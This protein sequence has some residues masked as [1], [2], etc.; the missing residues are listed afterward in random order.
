MSRQ[1]ILHLAPGELSSVASIYRRAHATGDWP[2]QLVLGQVKSLAKKERPGG[3]GDFRPI[4]IFS[5][6]YRIWSSIASQ[7]WLKHVSAIMDHRL[8]GN[9]SSH[10]ASHLWRAV[11]DEVELSHTSGNAIAGVVFDL[12]K[13][14]N[15]LP[16]VVCLGLGK[17]VGIDHGSL[18]AWAGALGQM[19][20]RF[21]VL[22]SVSPPVR[23]SCGFA[24]GCGMSCLAMMLLDQIW[25]EWVKHHS[26]LCIPM[27]YVDNWEILTTDVSQIDTAI[28]ATYAL[29]NRLDL[30]V[31]RQKSFTWA[32]SGGFRQVLRQRGYTVRLDTADLGAHVTYS[33]QLRNSSLIARCES[34]LDFWLKLRL[35]F[36]SH[37]QKAQV[38]LRAAW[39]RALHAASATHLGLKNV[40]SL[41]SAYMTALKLDRPGA[42]SFLQLHSDGFL[43]DPYAFILLQTLRDHRDLGASGWHIQILA[44][45]VNGGASMPVNSVTQVLANRLQYLKWAVLPD[46]RV[47]DGLSSFWL[48][49]INWSE[50]CLRF[51][52]AWHRCVSSQIAHRFEFQGFEHVDF[53]D[54]RAALA[55]LSPYLQGICRHNLNGSTM[56]NQ[57]AYHWSDDG[58]N[59]CRF[60]GGLDSL[61]HRYWACSYSMQ[62]R[63]GL[64]P[65][66]LDLVPSLPRA[67]TIRSWS[68][69]SPLCAPWW[70][71]LL[72]LP[73][74]FPPPAV[75]LKGRGPI[76][77]FTDG[78]CLHQDSRVYR[79][80]SWA[81]CLATP[82]QATVNAGF[83][84]AQVVASAE[85]PGLVQTSFRAELWAICAA[86]HYGRLSGRPVQIWTD[87]QGVHDRLQMVLASPPSLDGVD[88]FG[89]KV[90]G[91]NSDLWELLEDQ[92]VNIGAEHIRVFKV[93]AHQRVD[94][95]STHLEKWM[96][97]NNAA[98]D[99]AARMANFSRPR[100]V[101]TLWEQLAL[102]TDGLLRISHDI[103]T[104]HLA[105]AELWTGD[106]AQVSVLPG[107]RKP[108]Q[109]PVIE[110]QFVMEPPRQI[111][112]T[113]SIR[114]LGRVHAARL[115]HWWNGVVDVQQ[116]PLQWVSFSQLYLLYQLQ[117][118][119][120]G[121]VRCGRN[122]S[123]PDLHPA[124]LPEQWS[125][126]CRSKWFRLQLQQ[127]WKDSKWVVKTATLRPASSRLACHIGCASIP[128]KPQY[129]VQVDRW[130]EGV[131]PTITG[132][133][134][135]LDN[136]P[137]V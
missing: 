28:A 7:H 108:K 104:F 58:S 51:Q 44:D 103:R 46:G 62:L 86:L 37:H 18:Q 113:N 39:P 29:A 76:D 83:R 95:N 130:L 82:L 118:R 33:K 96:Y 132:H 129:L 128:V 109:Q 41:R 93:A 65:T 71:Y 80:A 133:G 14:F 25:H 12:E 99:T 35:A 63:S 79:M 116:F 77:L 85:L 13:A 11:L 27:S 125:F 23:P 73:S 24:E 19:S 32:T 78:S 121:A 17:I 56:T 72:D 135:A 36:G 98:V 102:Q 52:H 22:G 5:F 123:D 112:P 48:T 120:I 122:W 67:C 4:T 131:S 49:K 34:L 114:V 9:R 124:L 75:T 38:V 54:T 47:N 134:C 117:V 21:V 88:R 84:N 16:R 100:S 42:N 126:R 3:V 66:I 94:A 30:V 50:L 81:V 10:R 110:M 60:C 90:N 26:A 68:L 43:M 105:V 87:S 15:T 97:A 57:H 55:R 31:D 45:L 106:G 40:H 119:H 111:P 69:R 91:P 101:W 20:R 53:V 70:N 127:L 2:A 136:L 115:L 61:E 74:S 1:D 92:V 8:C 6:L 64:H 89:F 137:L 107:P 59:L